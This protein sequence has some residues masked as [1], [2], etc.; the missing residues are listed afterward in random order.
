MRVRRVFRAVLVVALAVL[1]ACSATAPSPVPA[2][3]A[4]RFAAYDFSENQVLVALYAE[5]ARRAGLPVVVQS[6]VATREV[7]EPALEQGVVDVVVDYLGTA[8]RFVDQGATGPRTRAQLHAHLAQRLAGR[9]VSVLTAAPAEDQNGFAVTTAFAA[10]HRV[11]KLS[12][13]APLASHLLFGAPP[14]CVD[15]PLCLPGLEK[16]Y[17]LHFR[18]VRSMPSR[19]ATV[20]ALTAGEIDLG[21]LETTDARLA[22][23]PVLLLLDD[24]SLQPPENVVPLVRT[25]VLDRWGDR[26]RRALDATSARLTTQEIATLNRAVELEGRT[27]AEAARQWWDRQ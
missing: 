25:A 9:G 6:G 1:T 2:R 18:E 8:D 11:G 4:I 22:T 21:L 14:E 19:A 16:V 20:E 15:R 5:A 26:L 10:A 12:E 3:D 27:P 13:L 7:V 24:R 17:G 23:A